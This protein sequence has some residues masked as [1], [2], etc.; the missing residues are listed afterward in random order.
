MCQNRYVMITIK[1]NHRFSVSGKDPHVRIKLY[2][3]DNRKMHPRASMPP[4]AP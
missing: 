4:C 2:R 1:T 3:N